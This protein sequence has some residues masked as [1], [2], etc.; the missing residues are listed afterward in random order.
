MIQKSAFP[1]SARVV[2]GRIDVPPVEY[3]FADTPKAIAPSKLKVEN[4]VA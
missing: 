4:A 2:F 3:N 1:E